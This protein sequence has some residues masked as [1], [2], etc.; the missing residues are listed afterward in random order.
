MGLKPENKTDH[1]PFE[2]VIDQV[3]KEQNV[4]LDTDLTWESLKLLVERFKALIK[5][6]TGTDF[7]QDPWDQLWGAIL[8]VFESWDNERACVYRDINGIPHV[9]KKV[10]CKSPSSRGASTYYKIRFNNMKTRQK[11][12]ESYKA[13]DMLKESDCSR[14][15]AQY[16][17]ASGDEYVFMNSEDYSQYTVSAEDLDGLEKFLTEGL[18][19]ITV[20]LLDDVVLS[21]ELPQSVNMEIV[22][23][24]PGIKGASASARTKPAILTTGLEVQVPEYLNTG[25]IIKVNTTNKQFM[26]RA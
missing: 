14:V 2:V 25:E 8:A 11:L 18:E 24:A 23:T 3:K 10:D 21:I 17:Y 26:S 22:E 13:D 15:Q 6:R 7:P 19:G 1:D 12:D 5:E 16:S 4:I 20:L 9:V